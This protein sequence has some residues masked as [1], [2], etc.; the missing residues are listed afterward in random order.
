[1]TTVTTIPKSSFCIKNSDGLDVTSVAAVGAHSLVLATQTS[2][3]RKV[4]GDEVRNPLEK[5]PDHHVSLEYSLHTSYDVTYFMV[6][7][8]GRA[9]V[10]RVTLPLKA[11]GV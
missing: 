9:L 11:P 5:F 6:I 2:C 4:V 10:G 1:M 8:S 7:P 3:A